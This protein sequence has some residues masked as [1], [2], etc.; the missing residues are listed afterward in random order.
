MDVHL[1]TVSAPKTASKNCFLN[2]F[3]QFYPPTLFLLSFN[4]PVNM[5]R[6]YLSVCFHVLFLFLTLLS[7]NASQNKISWHTCCFII[8]IIVTIMRLITI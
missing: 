4:I 6:A 3:A 8:S 5:L 7:N 2:D 1:L